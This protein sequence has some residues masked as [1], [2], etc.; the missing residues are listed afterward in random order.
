MSA[1]AVAAAPATPAK[2]AKASR[3]K[4]IKKASAHPKYADMIKKAVE[5][6]KER[7]GSS[8]QAIQK[9][10]TANF[11][12]GDDKVSAA[13]LKLALKR[14]VESGLLKRV[15]GVGASGSFRLAE[16]VSGKPKKIVKKPV[17]KK[18]K[19]AG[20]KKKAVAKPKKAAAAKPKKAVA[21]KKSPKPKKVAVKPKSPKKVKT[22]KKPK[23]LKAKKPVAKKPAKK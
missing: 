8:R 19:P 15:K 1:P 4:V 10:V 18:V 9:Y 12:V 17:A 21:A 20:E 2:K 16:K 22:P 14:G 7:G 6:L 5:A 23:A 13:H 11:K 3:P